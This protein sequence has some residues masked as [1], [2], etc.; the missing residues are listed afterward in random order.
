MKIG[1][2]YTGVTPELIELVEREIRKQLG[3]NI[4][5]LSYKDPSII[6]EVVENNYVTANP[7]ARLVKMFMQ[8]VKPRDEPNASPSGE[9]CVTITKLSPFSTYFLAF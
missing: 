8:A 1:L 9:T 7:T 3:S 2:V 6:S 5:L 4:E